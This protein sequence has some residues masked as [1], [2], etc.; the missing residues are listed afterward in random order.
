MKIKKSALEDICRAASN[1]FP[2]EF[3][4]LIASSNGKEIDEFVV[5]PATYGRN[6]S[7]LRI[8]LLP[9]DGS[10]VGSVH[11]HPSPNAMPS[12]ADVHVFRKTGQMHLIIAHPFSSE[13][14]R[15]FDAEGKELELEVVE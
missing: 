2:N 10:V 9:P 11:S 13:S 7:S 1:T 3:I 14:T 4:A 6:F 15:A 12:K 8:D 5:L